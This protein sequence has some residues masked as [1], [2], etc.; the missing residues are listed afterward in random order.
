MTDTYQG[1]E[2]WD[3][4]IKSIPNAYGVAGLMGNLF[5]ESSLNPKCVTGGGLKTKDQKL[6][7]IRKVKD[8]IIPGY[9]F[10]HDGIA[11]GLAQWRY[12]SRKEAFYLYCR[13]NKFDIDSIEGQLN[14]LFQ[15]IRTYKT[16]YNTICNAN[17]VAKAS[18]IV[19]ERYLKPAN[20]S[21]QA[22]TKRRNFGQEC[23]DLYAEGSET[24]VNKKYVVT[25]AP[26]VN[27]RIGNGKEYGSIL[28]AKLKATSFKWVATAE[29]GWFAVAVPDNDGKG[30]RVLWVS[31]E[32]SEIRSG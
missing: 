21:E 10:S 8:G 24:T 6:E 1:R 9:D 22:R 16:V 25:T 15:E 14:Y 11:F 27:L 28:Q 20:V 12:W 5:A 2:I 7:Y 13:E 29:N 18:D 23:Y 32:Y 19:M 3:I 26:R 31:P 4:L 17:T 30:K